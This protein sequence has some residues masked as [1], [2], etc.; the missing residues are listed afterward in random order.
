MHIPTTLFGIG[1]SS[2]VTFFVRT[3]Q[4]V[5]VLK[6][7]S[8][9]T[10]PIFYQRMAAAGRQV[11][12]Q[13]TY[14]AEYCTMRPFRDHPSQLFPLPEASGRF[15]TRTTRAL[16]SPSSDLGTL[17]TRRSPSFVCT[18]SISDFCFDE[19]ACHAN[20]VIVEGCIDVVVS[21]CSIV[22]A[23]DN[24]AMRTEP[25]LYLRH[26]ESAIDPGVIGRYAYPKA[27]ALQSAVGAIA[28][29]GS[30]I[31]R[32]VIASAFSGLKSM[33]LPKESP[34]KESETMTWRRNV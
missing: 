27:N 28:H 10:F 9:E 1:T 32:A 5:A 33:R 4:R 19:E 22:N 23:G 20:A 17:H 30:K 11:V 13:L 29:R 3:S 21:V 34:A 6:I 16:S 24:A 12:A 14:P 25:L 7:S 26:A 15:N 31:D 8:V 2:Q 18:A